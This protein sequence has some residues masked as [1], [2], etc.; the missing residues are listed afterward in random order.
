M[1]SCA[2]QECEEDSSYLSVMTLDIFEDSMTS[3]SRARVATDIKLLML[4]EIQTW[5][6]HGRE[7]K[8]LQLL[9]NGCSRGTL[10]WSIRK[11]IGPIA[12]K[13]LYTDG[14]RCTSCQLKVPRLR[15]CNIGS[16]MYGGFFFWQSSIGV[17]IS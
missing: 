17:G 1:L 12:S 4:I 6:I 16:E 15:N 13:T 2:S 14:E 10:R 11:E 9:V 8:S 3:R 5:M 7:F